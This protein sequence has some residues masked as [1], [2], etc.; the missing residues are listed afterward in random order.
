MLIGILNCGHF[1][2]RPDTPV[3]DYDSL[4]ADMLEGHGF[5]FK[6]WNVVDMEFPESVQDADGWLLGGSRHGV[7]DD[8]PFIAPLKAFVQDAYA[9]KVPVVG[10]CF[11][12]QLIAQAL[13]GKAEKFSG[14]WGIGHTDYAFEGETL[15]M[16]A[17]HQDQ[18]TVVPPDARVVGS[19][20]FCANAAL[21]YD[22]PAFSLQA[23]PEFN[24]A[25]MDLLYDLRAPKLV[26]QSK[27]D[28]ARVRAKDANHN[29]QMA[30]RIA[31]FFKEAAA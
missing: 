15:T 12:H 16:N 26:D 24:V 4:Y 19:N 28:L 14:G 20:D 29:Q 3:R 25:E 18:V 21:V 22:G 31:T 7:Y 11:G 9:A 30:L 17:F 1:V 13:G 27:I 23:H 2:H 6:A 5:D 8:V 10:V